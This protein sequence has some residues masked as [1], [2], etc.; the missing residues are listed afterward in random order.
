MTGLEV[1]AVS[2]ADEL[3]AALALRTEVFVAEQ[4]VPVELEV[5]DQDPIAE[6]LVVV[7]DGRV[8]A[9]ARLV[10]DGDVTKLGRLAVARHARR[11]G[12]A[13]LLLDES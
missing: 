5:D 12:L 13:R 6:H 3:R 10:H 7:Q 9:T 8:L 1:R 4:G 11:R 2:G